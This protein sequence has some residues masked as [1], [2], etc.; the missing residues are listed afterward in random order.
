MRRSTRAI[1]H[2]RSLHER[3]PRGVLARLVWRVALVCKAALIA[4]F[5]L[6]SPPA[7]SF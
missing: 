7:D 4:A 2:K 1:S 3:R 5:N 6:G